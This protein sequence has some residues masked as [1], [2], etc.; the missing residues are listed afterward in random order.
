MRVLLWKMDHPCFFD[1]F[2]SVHA[3]GDSQPGGGPFSL[4]RFDGSVSE[5]HGDFF[6]RRLIGMDRCSKLVPY[7]KLD[8]YRRSTRTIGSEFGSIANEHASALAISR[9]MQ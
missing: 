4:F 3:G 9:R 8:R 1:Y 7:S 6:V 5:L 2:H